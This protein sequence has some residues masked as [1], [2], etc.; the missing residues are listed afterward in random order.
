MPQCSIITPWTLNQSYE[1]HIRPTPNPNY[2]KWI[3]IL[4]LRYCQS[5]FFQLEK[6]L[7]LLFFLSFFLFV[8]CSN[9]FK[10]LSNRVIINDETCVQFIILISN[11]YSTQNNKFVESTKMIDFIKMSNVIRLTKCL[12]QSSVNPNISNIPFRIQCS[13][14][15]SHG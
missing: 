4:S 11:E 9:Y 1:M 10:P 6:L 13:I 7:R 5:F 14:L 8:R 15:I 12:I 2:C 3:G